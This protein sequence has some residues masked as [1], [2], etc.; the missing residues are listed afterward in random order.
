M[1]SS[2]KMKNKVKTAPAEA[3]ITPLL[4]NQAELTELGLKKKRTKSKKGS[5][6]GQ[7]KERV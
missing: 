3:A 7:Y 1:K 6:F 5:L 4:Q 2:R